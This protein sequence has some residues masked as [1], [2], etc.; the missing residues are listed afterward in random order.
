MVRSHT[1]RD[2]L[3]LREN[4]KTL[5]FRLFFR[6]FNNSVFIFCI[7][8]QQEFET[9]LHVKPSNFAIHYLPFLVSP[10]ILWIFVCVETRSEGSITAVELLRSF[11]CWKMHRKFLPLGVCHYFTADYYPNAIGPFTLH[12]FCIVSWKFGLTDGDRKVH[13]SFL[14]DN[15]TLNHHINPMIR[16]NPEP[17]V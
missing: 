16:I 10:G 3:V 13:P 4:S 7:S 11:G 6:V 9:C 5:K 1:K 17:C 14:T 8:F 15:T 2:F 12:F